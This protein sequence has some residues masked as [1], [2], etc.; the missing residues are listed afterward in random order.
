[1]SEYI[2]RCTV[3]P[4]HAM[5]VSRGSGGTAPLI[6]NFRWIFNFMQR[7]IYVQE[8]RSELPLGMR[9]G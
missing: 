8:K 9:L 2:V 1:V 3:V 4:V 5:K 7:S 6:L